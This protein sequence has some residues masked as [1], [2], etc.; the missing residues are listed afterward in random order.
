MKVNVMAIG[1]HPDDVELGC[2]GTLYNHVRK[3]QKVAIVDLTE[4]E[5]GSRGTIATRYTEA[6]AAS[7][8]LQLSYRHNLKM[9][10]GFFELN[11]ANI[12]KIV[13]ILRLHQPDVVLANAPSDRHP[14]HGRAAAL[15]RDAAFLSGL[16]KIETEWEGKPQ[17]PW[18]PK[19]V[20]HYIQDRFLEPSFIVD[21]SESMEVKMESVKCYGTQFFSE[22]NDGAPVTYISSE[23]FLDKIKDRASLLGKR[24]GVTY[25]EGFI[26][27]TN[28]GIADLDQLLYPEIA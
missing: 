2:A 10:D 7:A 3:G 11:R 19:R 28:L 25:G 12:L 13:Q 8:V 4:G 16:I 27:D 21:V 22:S 9:E 17:E 14:D 20:F 6:A 23:K 1:A 5:L 26:S 15:I 18:R 24:I